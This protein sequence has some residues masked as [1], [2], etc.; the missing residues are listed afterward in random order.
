MIL[1]E[2]GRV[3]AFLAFG[4]FFAFGLL[5]LRPIYKRSRTARKRPGVIATF[6]LWSGLSVFALAILGMAL[7]WGSMVLAGPGGGGAGGAAAGSGFLLSGLIIM[8]AGLGAIVVFLCYIVTIDGVRSSINRVNR[9]ILL[10]HK[11]AVQ[12]AQTGE[13]PVVAS[14]KN[15]SP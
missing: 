7:V 2:G 11:R 12:P 4:V 9:E 6:T 5:A 14:P 15:E 1:S 8:A 10:A 3:L 13:T